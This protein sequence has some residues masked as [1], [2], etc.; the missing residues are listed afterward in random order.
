M[1]KYFSDKGFPVVV[2]P[3]KAKRNTISLVD[4]AKKH[5][6]LGLLATTWDSLDVCQP[7]VA[8]AGVL[9]WTAPRYELKVPFDHWLSAI[10]VFPICE[11]PKLEET[12]EGGRRKDEG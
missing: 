1:P 5:N 2:C 3:W 12:L 8:E 10:R 11:L 9:A 7:S 6:L 4:T